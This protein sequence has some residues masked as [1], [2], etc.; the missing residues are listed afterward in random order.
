YLRHYPDEYNAVN[1]EQRRYEII[2][3][4]TDTTGAVFL[5]LTVG[6]ARCHDHKYDPI[7]Q[8]D[9]FRLQSFFA[10]LWPVDVPAVDQAR[11]EEYEKQRQAWEAETAELRQ[12]MAKLEEPARKSF[13]AKRR[14]RFPKEY[15]EILDIPEEQRT[16]L[17]KQIAVMA[18]K[19]I[20]APMGE[21]V[22]TMKADVKEK[23]ETLHKQMLERARPAPPP[24]P[25]APD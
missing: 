16:P 19:Q 21:I 17:Q 10:A 15:Q 22:K 14:V 25:R 5:G 6:C 3:D 13:M 20:D 9:Y 2:T 4:I 24:P 1:L 11:V 23:W 8:D 7:T 12:Q 18:E